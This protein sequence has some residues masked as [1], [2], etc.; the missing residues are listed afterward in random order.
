[1]NCRASATLKITSSSLMIVVMLVLPQR[2]VT[3]TQSRQGR[4]ATGE[5]CRGEA[6][7]CFFF[8]PFVQKERLYSAWSHLGEKVCDSGIMTRDN[9]RFVFRQSSDGLPSLNHVTDVIDEGK[10]VLFPHV[11][12]EM[13]GIRGEDDRSSRSLNPYDLKAI[14][15][16]AHPV[17]VEAR[18]HGRMPAMEDGAAGIDMPYHVNHGINVKWLPEERMTHTTACCIGHLALLNVKPGVRKVIEIACVIK[19]QMRDD[20]VRDRRWIATHFFRARLQAEWSACGCGAP[21]QIG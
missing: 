8:R 9:A 1:M 3:L 17:Q 18:C 20:H 14:R 19:V 11:I 15:M 4:N 13:S 16:S 5:S 6:L 21:R 10:G 7:P 2:P 12:I